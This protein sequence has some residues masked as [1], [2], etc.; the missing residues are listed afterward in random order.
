MAFNVGLGL[1]I[2]LLA[3]KKLVVQKFYLQGGFKFQVQ[4][5]QRDA[6]KSR[7]HQV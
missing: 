2:L 7:T 5:V 1:A 6:A 4:K 3:L